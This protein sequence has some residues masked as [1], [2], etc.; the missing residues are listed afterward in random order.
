MPLEGVPEWLGTP[1][2]GNVR[3][4]SAR[5]RSTQGQFMSGDSAQNGAFGNVVLSY[6][7]RRGWTALRAKTAR[8]RRIVRVFLWLWHDRGSAAWSS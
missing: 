1:R 5:H 7:H 8:H 3:Y 2:F 4:S 6:A